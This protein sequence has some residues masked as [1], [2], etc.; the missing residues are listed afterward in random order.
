[1]PL[2]A[3][4]FSFVFVV[5]TFDGTPRSQ[6]NRSNAKAHVRACVGARVRVI[7][8]LKHSPHGVLLD[9]GLRTVLLPISNTMLD[10]M[11]TL[12]ASSGAFQILLM[13]VLQQFVSNGID[14]RDVDAFA[15]NIQDTVFDRK[16]PENIF[17]R[18]YSTEVSGGAKGTQ[19]GILV[20]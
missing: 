14:L 19:D 16:L 15:R 7:T 5:R 6:R 17:Q 2:R 12:I 1:V 9:E 3:E 13:A 4:Q 20:W 10:W 8:G 18:R 11:H